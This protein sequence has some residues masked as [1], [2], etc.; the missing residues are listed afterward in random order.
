MGDQMGEANVLH[1]L[2]LRCFWTALEGGV[3]HRI[4]CIVFESIRF[5]CLVLQ[6]LL[7]VSSR[8]CSL[9]FR[10][11]TALVYATPIE[12][13]ARL[14]S[15][16]GR[17]SKTFSWWALLSERPMIVRYAIWIRHLRWS[18]VGRRRRWWRHFLLQSVIFTRS[19]HSLASWRWC[20]C[21]CCSLGPL[22]KQSLRRVLPAF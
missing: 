19:S 11:T 18:C 13:R 3:I 22:F 2:I 14:P 9:S 20:W 15:G 8:A 7:I 4:P 12:L 10:L 16:V 17:C 6:R 1:M 21:C 5:Y